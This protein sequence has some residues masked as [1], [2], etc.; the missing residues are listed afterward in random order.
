MNNFIVRLD[1]YPYRCIGIL[2][3]KIVFII[4]WQGIALINFYRTTGPNELK[5]KIGIVILYSS[6]MNILA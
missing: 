3:S 1:K 5:S 6:I 2:N 4:S